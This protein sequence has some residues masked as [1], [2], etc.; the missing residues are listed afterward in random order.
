MLDRRNA[1][2]F[3]LRDRGEMLVVAGLGSCVY[4]VF[5]AGDH[6]LNFYDWGAM[7]SAAMIGLGLALARPEDPVVVFTGDGEMLMGLGAFATIAQ[8]EPPNLSIIILD[9]GQYA[10]TGLQNS[11][12]SHGTDLAAIAQASGLTHV[13]TL[14]DPQELGDLRVQLHARSG[15]LVG[16][17]KVQRGGVS[18]T[19]PIKDGV[20]IK[21]RF[22]DALA[23]FS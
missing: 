10:E 5:A 1:V 6:P 19:T 20:T 11:A 23:T 15:T 22:A 13:E 2:E 8:H 18:R 7:G 16:T 14:S 12:T 9:N 3:L 4:D 21:T 17:L